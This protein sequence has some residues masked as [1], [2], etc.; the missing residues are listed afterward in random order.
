[1]EPSARMSENRCCS[2]LCCERCAFLKKECPTCHK[3]TQW[4]SSPVVS[5]ISSTLKTD[6]PFGCG[7]DC[8]YSDLEKH[9]SVCLSALVSCPHIACSIKVRRRHLEKHLEEECAYRIETCDPTRCSLCAT[10]SGLPLPSPPQLPPRDSKG[11]EEQ[12]LSQESLTTFADNFQN[13]DVVADNY[14]SN[15]RPTSRLDPA[16]SAASSPNLPDA[17]NIM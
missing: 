12:R 17:C 6:C 16:K 15:N 14:K 11:K 7:E 2:S 1:M 10:R 13:R 3:P 8:S 9:K 5:K 4:V